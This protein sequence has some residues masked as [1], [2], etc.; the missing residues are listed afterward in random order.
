MGD[1]F[2]Q[3]LDFERKKQFASATVYGKEDCKNCWAK[4]YCSGGC[5]Q[6]HAVLRGYPETV[7]IV[8]ELEK[9][10]VE[11]AI[12][13]KGGDTLRECFFEN[14]VYWS[15]QNGWSNHQRYFIKS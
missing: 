13:I 2:S 6:Q 10:R 8:C 11:C 5:M 3:S 9:K 1:V 4:F 7:Q 14:R 15:R 12:M